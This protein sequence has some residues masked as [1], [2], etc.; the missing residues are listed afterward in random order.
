MIGT[1]TSAVG[2]AFVAALALLLGASTVLGI[3]VGFVAFAVMTV[4]F[5]MA[6][7]RQFLALERRIDARFPAPPVGTLPDGS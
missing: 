7:Y 3:I 2:G 6:G 5:L 1:I 4:T